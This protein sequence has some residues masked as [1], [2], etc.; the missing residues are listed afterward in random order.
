MIQARSYQIEAVHSVYTYFSANSGNPLIAMPTGTGKSV[1]IALFLQSVFYYYPNQKILVLT[2]VKELIEQNYAKLMQIW[3]NAPAGIN[4]AGVGKRDT[5]HKIIFG[6]I[7]SVIGQWQNLGHVDLIL[8]DEAHLVSPNEGTMYQK[9]IAGLKSV[10]PYLKVIGLTATPWRI[11][12]GKITDDGLFTDF[13]FDITGLEAFNRLIA[14]GYLCTLIPKKTEMLLDVEGIHIRGGDFVASELQHAVDKAEITYAALKESMEVGA[15]RHKWLIFCSGIEHAMHT[16]EMLNSMGIPC[17]CIHSKLKK[18]EREQILA[19]YK[20][21]K[22]RALTNN[23]VLTTGFDAPDIDLII[24]LRPTASPVLWVQMLGRGTRPVYAP[25]FDLSTAEGRL[26]AISHGPKQNCLVLDFAGNSKRLGP[27][28]DPVIPRKKGKGTGEAPVKL[29][30]RCGVYNHA[31]VRHCIYCGYEFPI[32]TKITQEASTVEIVRSEMPVV[33]EFKI[34]HITYGEHRK[35]DTAPI[36][37][38]SYYCGLKRFDDYVCIQHAKDS[39]AGRKAGKW[40]RERSDFPVP[41]TTELALQAS[42]T[43]KTAT[44]VRV[45]TNKK[46]PEILAYCFDGT[47][48]GKEE[49][50]DADEGPS[51]Q[52]NSSRPGQFDPLP[53]AVQSDDIPF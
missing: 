15:D 24:V 33:E 16:S 18:T 40:W 41:D 29:C 44:H 21:G 20:A 52:C 53:V 47:C 11:G 1:V 46:Y 8:I 27:I 19:D 42:S 22:Y 37:K 35:H 45:W 34:D 9:L 36:L 51:V 26:L 12:Q 5:L 32:Q 39:F 25:G 31:S 30:D 2:H 10:N 38:V 43:L 3:P 49:V 7:A 50:S 4:S 28:N 23:N 6:G 48:F 13:C 17:A 14:E